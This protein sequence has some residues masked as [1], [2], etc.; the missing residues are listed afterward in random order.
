MR[1]I[2]ETKLLFCAN[3]LSEKSLE[4]A[5][6]D[7]AEDAVEPSLITE[8]FQT[9]LEEKG[10]PG[11][12]VEWSL[13][14][15]QGDGV[16]FYGIV[17]LDSL[18]AV[19]DEWKEIIDGI[20]KYDPDFSANISRNSYGN[21]YSHWGTM[22]VTGEVDSDKPEA[23]KA[24]E[25]FEKRLTNYIQNISHELEKIGY[26]EI[27]HEQGKERFLETAEANDW[28]FFANGVRY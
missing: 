21:H 25:V 17:D 4:K 5:V 3:E 10:L 23:D 6:S 12:D 15:C 2:T 7:F 14:C 24:W 1:E 19:S 22:T 16:A 11:L 27:E 20:K 26:D 18:S 13:N 28:E 8:N 9:I